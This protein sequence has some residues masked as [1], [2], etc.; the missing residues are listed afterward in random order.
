MRSLEKS[1]IS[2]FDSTKTC[3]P[4][5]NKEQQPVVKTTKGYEMLSDEPLSRVSS[6]KSRR[7]SFRSSSGKKRKNSLFDYFLNFFRK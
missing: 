4:S 3:V 7:S 5:S 2:N 6:V 1:K